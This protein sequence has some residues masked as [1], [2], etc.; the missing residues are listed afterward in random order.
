VIL[1]FGLSPAWQQ[2]MGFAGVRRGEVNRAAEVHWCASGKAVN[3]ALALARLEVDVE[4]VSS[5]GG[6][7][8]AA[9][10]E[11]IEAAGIRGHW[12]ET[13]APT[14]VCT[15]IIETASSA[16]ITELVENTPG[17]SAVE[18]EACRA[19]F[20]KNAPRAELVVLTGSLPATAPADFYRE[21]LAAVACPAVLDFR[22]PELLAALE[23][24]PLLVKP[25]REELGH[26]LGRAITSAADVA[27]G[28]RELRDRGAQWVAITAGAEA[29]YV[30]G[31]NQEFRLVP[32]R[33]KV[34]NPIASGDCLAAGFAWA[35]RQGKSVETALRWGVAA[36]SLNVATLLPARI[37]PAAVEELSEAVRVEHV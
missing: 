25:N 27:A 23:R 24:K 36:A 9:L 10:R 8:G 18:L 35:V 26:T 5:V 19:A 11:E 33:M 30:V 21:L 34:V 32:P 3:V 37:E 7:T 20:V 12:I 29:V 2:I 17:V 4:L 16:V 15:T 13:V 1:S 28:A 6:R 31:P 22:G 14:R